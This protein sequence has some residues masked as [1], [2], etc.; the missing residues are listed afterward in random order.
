MVSQS[1]SNWIKMRSG[2]E[3]R[4]CHLVILMLYHLF[5]I[6]INLYGFTCTLFD[7]GMPISYVPKKTVQNS[8]AGLTK[9][10]AGLT[11][12]LPDSWV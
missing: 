12:S 2:L 5:Y 8:L 10:L 9:I 7:S 1:Y 6:L 11:K 4:Y 3:L